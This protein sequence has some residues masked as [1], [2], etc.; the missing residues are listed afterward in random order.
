MQYT[1]ENPTVVATRRAAFTKTA[2]GDFLRYL[3][4]KHEAELAAMGIGTLGIELMKDGAF[5]RVVP[6]EQLDCSVDH[7]VSLHLGGTND[8]DNLMLV[9]TRINAL[10]DQLETAQLLKA[11]PEAIKTIVPVNG[12]KVPFIPGGF[13]RARGSAL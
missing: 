1:L 3:A 7:I 10:K 5:P 6:G 8:I 2:K 12:A 11:K 4:E 9:P 13:Q